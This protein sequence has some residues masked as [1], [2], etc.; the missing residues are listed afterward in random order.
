MLYLKCIEKEKYD[1]REK[2]IQKREKIL[3]SNYEEY[4]LL[5]C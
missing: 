4:N 1:R 5:R 2:L 3:P